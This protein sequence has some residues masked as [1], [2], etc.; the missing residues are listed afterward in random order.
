M[1]Q[2][3]YRYRTSAFYGYFPPGVKW[4]L[5]VNTL[6]YVLFYLGG[7]NVQSHMLTLVALSAEAAVHN[8]FVWQIFTYMFLHGGLMHLVFNML[9]LWFFGLQLEQDWGTRRFLKYYFYCGMAAGVCVLVFNVAAAALTGSP[10]WWNVPTVGASGAIFGVLVAFGVLYPDQTVLMLPFF[11][12]IKAKYMVMIYAGIELLL[13][14]GPSTGVSNIAH[15]GGMA[16]GYLYLKRSLPVVRL[17]GLDVQG[18]YNRW[19]MARAKKKFQVY[20]RKR[21]GRGPW[22]N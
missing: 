13:I 18:A 5:I 9:A 8:L 14:M 4:L 16:F 3:K 10:V 1:A 21:D 19:R 12:P 2:P 15:L 11:F 17:P 6:V 7:R 20:L 22:V